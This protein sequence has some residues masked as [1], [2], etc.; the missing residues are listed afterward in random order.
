MSMKLARVV[1]GGLIQL[2]A[3]TTT[4]TDGSRAGAND[5]VVW[6]GIDA[7]GAGFIWSIY[8]D[9][10]G[11][12]ALSIEPLWPMG[13][14]FISA[15]APTLVWDVGGPVTEWNFSE[16]GIWYRRSGYYTIDP[17]RWQPDNGTENTGRPCLPG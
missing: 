15:G 9:T 6:N 17:T 11:G 4:A 7:D 12:S 8:R 3:C 2:A 13:S 5:G 10:P 16:H 1:M 14:G